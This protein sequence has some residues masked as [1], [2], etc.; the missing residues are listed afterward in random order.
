MGNIEI[1]NVWMCANSQYAIHSTNTSRQFGTRLLIMVC[2]SATKPSSQHRN[3]QSHIGSLNVG[4]HT[5]QDFTLQ[6]N[7][8]WH[9]ALNIAEGNSYTQIP[10]R[11]VFNLSPH[12][13][14]YPPHESKMYIHIQSLARTHARRNTQRPS[15]HTEN[16]TIIFAFLQPDENIFFSMEIT[17]MPQKQIHHPVQCKLYGR[18]ANG[19]NIRDDTQHQFIWSNGF[20]YARIISAECEQKQQNWC[21]KCHQKSFHY[22]KLNCDGKENATY[23]QVT[24]FFSSTYM[25]AYTEIYI[26]LHFDANDI[27]KKEMLQIFKWNHKLILFLHFNVICLN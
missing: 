23:K 9:L 12:K 24:L 20:H 16:R 8:A 21:N 14:I 10:G 27:Q 2:A 4:E 1:D 3:I 5:I 22:I 15:L 17:E 19:R 6:H 11:H 26:H 25:Y 7:I 18:K 13:N